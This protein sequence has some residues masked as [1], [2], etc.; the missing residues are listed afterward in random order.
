MIDPRFVILGAVLNGVGSVSYL[1]GT[2]RGNVKPN[3]VTWLLWAIAPLIAWSAELKQ[4][5]GIVSL[6]TF[7]S[8]FAPLL[9]FLASFHQRSP[10]KIGRF[11]VVCGLL[12]LVGLGLW[13]ATRAADVAIVF[14]IVADA[15]A[16]I[17]TLVKSVK[18]PKTENAF[19]YLCSAGGAG[20]TLLAISR[21]SVAE[22]AFPV[23]L[24]VMSLLLFV[25]VK[26]P[27]KS[28]FHLRKV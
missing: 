17:P 23:Y 4:G 26:V 25:A 5:V 10:W 24:F 18:S 15:L 8:G 13:Y 1:I 2:L 7:V 16:A 12:S 27:V 22:A 14:A 9:I 3:R 20:V 28:V 6:F 11:D 21:W 19:V